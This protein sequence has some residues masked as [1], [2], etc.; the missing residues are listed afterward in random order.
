[1]R[2]EKYI[3]VTFKKK[4]ELSLSLSLSLSLMSIFGKLFMSGNDG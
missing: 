1:M 3:G 4:N 2:G